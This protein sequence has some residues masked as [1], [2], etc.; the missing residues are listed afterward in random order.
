MIL[1]YFA[2]KIEKSFAE[3]FTLSHFLNQMR[4]IE[5]KKTTAKK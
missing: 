4:K 5:M 2:F 1:I 3:Y